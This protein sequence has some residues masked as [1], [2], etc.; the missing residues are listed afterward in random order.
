MRL[1][2]IRSG[3]CDATLDPRTGAAGVV[4]LP[5][6]ASK[7][8]KVGKG[9]LLVQSKR[10]RRSWV[11]SIASDESG[12]WVACGVGTQGA[13]GHL[14]LW[15]LPSRRITSTMPTA[16]HP[17]AVIMLPGRII[18]A[19]NEDAVYHWGRSGKMTARVPCSSR[20]VFSL[21]ACPSKELICCAG[22]A[23]VDMYTSY[24]LHGSTL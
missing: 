21:A 20:S 23:S 13:C 16:G 19:G 17:Q 12:K 14:A 11:S 3:R 8:H 1:W 6:P 18:S 5:A 24:L 10:T 9:S 4:G 2:D 22:D 15:H 7:V